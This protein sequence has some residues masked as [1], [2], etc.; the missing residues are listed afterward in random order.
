[1][2]ANTPASLGYRLAAEW[3]PQAAVWLSWPHRR[4][5]WPDHFGPIPDVY[6]GVVRR[7]AATGQTV[8]VVASGQPLAEATGMLG[9]VS[10]VWL[11][12]MPTN[13]SWLR[14]SGPVFLTPRCGQE[15]LP[16]AAVA[17]AY[18]AWGGKYPPW[19]DDAALG[20][21]IAES[22]GMRV[23]R[24]AMVLEGGAIDTDGEGTLLV[25]RNCV[26][27]DR[28]NP[29]MSASQIERELAEQLAIERVIWT[30]GDLAGDDTDGHIDQLARFVA[31]GRVLA[32]RQADPLDPN[33]SS[34]AGNLEILRNATDAAG[35]LLE[36]VPVDIPPRFQRHG[37]QLPASYLN[38]L[39][40][41][42]AVLVPIFA[43]P[44]DEPALRTIESCFPGRTLVPVD[45]RDLVWGRGAVHC[46]TRDQ[47]A[48]PTSVE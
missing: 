22:L 35:R 48:W 44:A 20:G 15:A 33:Q 47:P 45:C 46:I 11:V 3:E 31:P 18:N 40:T 32:A 10:D 19:G 42:F 8:K 4:A 34:L 24:G 25:N 9:M 41:N 12:D 23:F 21:R 2:P 6:A 27:D 38:F 7:I 30:G 28:R 5:T 43:D 16:P 26:I 13:D 36:V 39:V 1:M 14:D 37:V 17:F 29:G